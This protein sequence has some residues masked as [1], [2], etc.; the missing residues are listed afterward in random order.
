MDL[1]YLI[2][3]VLFFVAIDALGKALAKL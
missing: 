3:I 1:V 2:G